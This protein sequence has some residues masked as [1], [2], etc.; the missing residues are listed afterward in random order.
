[1]SMHHLH[2]TFNLRNVHQIMSALLS[3]DIYQS[4]L[5]LPFTLLCE[6]CVHTGVSDSSNV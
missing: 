4:V 2:N 5:Y 3:N 1:M 6:L